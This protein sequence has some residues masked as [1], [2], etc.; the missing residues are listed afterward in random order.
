MLYSVIVAWWPKC[1]LCPKG[2]LSKTAEGGSSR[3]GQ[4]REWTNPAGV[5]KT[6]GSWEENLGWPGRM[7]TSGIRILPTLSLGAP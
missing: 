5:G 6:N 4:R 7:G 3:L 1:I 2:D